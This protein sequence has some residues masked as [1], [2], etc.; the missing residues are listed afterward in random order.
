MPLGIIVT[1]NLFVFQTH[2]VVGNSMF[3]NL[4]DNDYL[5]TSKLGRTQALAGKLIGEDGEYIPKR[6]QVVV[7]KYPK[8]PDLIFVKRVVGLPGERVVVSPEGTVRVYNR[9][10]P[11]GFNPD[12]GYE[13]SDT[14]TGTPTDTTVPEGSI[15]VIGDNRAPNGSSDS[16]EWGPVPSDK[17]IGTAAIRLLPLSDF[18]LL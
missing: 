12:V 18:K 8:Q 3:P 2:H 9:Q 14:F 16:R 10:N 7:F 4:K 13:P 6:G 1:L 5:I 11:E 15:F 17:I